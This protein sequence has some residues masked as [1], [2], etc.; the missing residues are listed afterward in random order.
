MKIVILTIAMCCLA[1]GVSLHAQDFTNIDFTLN[2]I[3]GEQFTLQKFLTTIRGDG[4][5]PKKGAVIISFWALWCQ[6][7]KEEM[8][9]LRET[10]EKY[11]DRNLHY[12]AINTDTPRSMAKVKAYLTAQK[13]P[14][15]FL[16]DPN[17]EVFKNLNVQS[18]PFSMILDSSGKL[19]AKRV[20]FIA[21][22]EKEIEA[23]ILKTIE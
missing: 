2:T 1:F 10:F 17:S 6:P 21:G 18:M 20:G 5:T 9:A 8:K 7:C 16:L 14:Y 19:I 15:I 11:Q 3:D 4:A 22:D 13:L 23:D 12:V